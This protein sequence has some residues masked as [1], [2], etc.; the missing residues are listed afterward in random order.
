MWG[1]LITNDY[2]LDE[3]FTILE[4]TRD[5]SVALD[6]INGV[7]S[8]ELFKVIHVDRRTI[9]TTRSYVQNNINDGKFDG[10]SFTD[11]VVYVQMKEHQ[12]PIDHVF[13]Y[14]RRDFS[15]L[16]VTVIPHYEL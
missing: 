9:E 8:G 2:I 16:D 3:T 15:P 5:K 10:M 4:K 6:I 14:N 13:T 11:W 12:P 7:Y 1:P